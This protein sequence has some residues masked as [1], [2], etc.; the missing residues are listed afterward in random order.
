MSVHIPVAELCSFEHS[1]DFDVLPKDW[2]RGVRQNKWQP[3]VRQRRSARSKEIAL[4]ASGENLMGFD[5]RAVE[6]MTRV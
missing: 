6:E 1:D 4:E 3:A 2:N 5:Q